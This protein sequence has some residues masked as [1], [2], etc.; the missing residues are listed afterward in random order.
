M[1][2]LSL[3]SLFLS[4]PHSSGFRNKSKVEHK[5]KAQASGH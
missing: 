1:E 5:E 2:A 3:T 4:P